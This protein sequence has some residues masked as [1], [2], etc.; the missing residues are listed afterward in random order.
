MLIFA[1]NIVATFAIFDLLATNIVC[2]NKLL[3]ECKHRSIF[4]KA[5]NKI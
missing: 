4:D 1:I 5:S 3:I 2:N